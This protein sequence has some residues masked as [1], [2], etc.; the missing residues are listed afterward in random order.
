MPLSPRTSSKQRQWH[1]RNT[2]MVLAL[3][4]RSLLRTASAFS[5]RTNP[6]AR[7]IGLSH[8]KADGRHTRLKSPLLDYTEKRCQ[9]R[10]SSTLMPAMTGQTKLGDDEIEIA[11]EVY[12][13]DVGGDTIFANAL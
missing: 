10:L 11:K 5:S 9:Y 3:L 6:T 1:L 12:L 7:K 4:S 8:A 13:D 2:T